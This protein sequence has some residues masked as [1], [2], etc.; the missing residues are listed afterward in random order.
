MNIQFKLEA[1]LKLKKFKEHEEKIN[2]GKVLK[3]IGKKEMEILSLNNNLENFYMEQSD[4][5]KKGIDGKNLK[6]YTI[7]IQAAREKIGHKQEKLMK[8]KKKYEEYR[9]NLNIIMGEVKVLQKLKDEHKKKYHKYQ[10]TKRE[11]EIEDIVNM[12]EGV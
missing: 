12:R 4:Q 3:K 11:R 10:N 6:T 9:E 1:L 8:L 5:T 7:L 2:L